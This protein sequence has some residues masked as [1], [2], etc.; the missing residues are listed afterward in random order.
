MH[1]AHIHYAEYRNMAKMGIN[2]PL[3][4][5]PSV[6]PNHRNNPAFSVMKINQI[7]INIKVFSLQLQYYILFGL[8]LWSAADPYLDYGIK[9]TD[10]STIDNLWYRFTDHSYA[11]YYAWT[12]G[13]DIFTRRLLF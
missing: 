4:V 8:Q 6:T 12:T 7:D 3:W 1:G 11:E 2:V 10:I 5:S 13:F 9:M